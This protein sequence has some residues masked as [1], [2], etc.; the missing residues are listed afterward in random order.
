MCL[1][2]CV[3]EI[4]REVSCVCVVR[5]SAVAMC[6]KSVREFRKER[7]GSKRLSHASNNSDCCKG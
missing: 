7:K 6:N 4:L 3:F 5:Y 1:K 2:E